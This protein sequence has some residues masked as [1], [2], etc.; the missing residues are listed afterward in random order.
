MFFVPFKVSRS[1]AF[2]TETRPENF[3]TETKTRKNGSR[4]ES[5]DRD[6]VSRPVLPLLVFF[7]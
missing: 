1:V 5:R 6:Q 3:K 4:E 2:E 7:H